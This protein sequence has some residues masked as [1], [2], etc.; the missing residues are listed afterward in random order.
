LIR[1]APQIEAIEPMT[2]FIG[3]EQLM[4][5]SGRTSLVRLGAN[6]SAFGI[7]PLAAQA[8][9][10]ELERLS[11]YGDPESYELREAL[12]RKHGVRIEEVMVGAG[13]DDLMGLVVRA[14]VAP[15]GTALTSRGSYPTFNYHVH[16][17]GGRLAWVDYRDDGHIDLEALAAAA[18]RE[19]ASVVYLANPDNPSGTFA[20]R[21]DIARFIDALPR[22]TVLLL[23]EAYADFVD[24]GD[25]VPMQ[26]EDRIVRTWTFSKAH[27]MAG[28]RIGYALASERVLGILQKIRLHYGV[29]RNAQVGALA[30]LRDEAF[31]RHVV[32]SVE[33][34][35]AD[36]ARIATSLGLG[37][38]PSKTNFVCIDLGSAPRAVAV[39]NE[40]LR[41]GVWIRKPGLPPLDRYVRVSAGTPPMREAFAQA[42]AEVV[43]AVPSGAA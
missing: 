36:Y 37:F 31:H 25:L 42:F 33:E 39:M 41:R 18:H 27:G 12:A 30:S 23:D 32:A 16:G 8:M 34:A 21:D 43:N 15:G 24:R 38:I 4:R 35:R 13:I 22:D 3:P 1:P 14:F 9:A 26:I 17:Y 28:A 5:E 29:N 19:R 2:P 11:W 7:S 6:E 10:G 40:L 20:H